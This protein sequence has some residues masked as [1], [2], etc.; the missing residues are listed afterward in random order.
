MIAMPEFVQLKKHVPSGTIII[1]RPE[2][3]NALSRDTVAALQQA[4]DDFHGER[5]VRAIILT[6]SG[7]T[8][9]SGT[10]LRELSEIAKQPNAMFEWQADVEHFQQLLETMWR[11]PKPII[12]AASGWCTGTGLALLL[13]C[14]HVI[15]SDKLQLWIPEA[16]RG[17]SSGLTAPLLAFRIGAGRANRLLYD[18]Q[19]IG[20]TPAHQL[21]IVHEIV[22]DDFVW[23]RAHQVANDIARGAAHSNLMAKQLMNETI[24]ETLLTQLAIGAAQTATARTTDAAIEGIT[25]FL[26][27]RPPKFI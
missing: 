3:R 18:A 24:G 26:E 22:A 23:A 7:N 25:A 13:A 5:S 14:D 19:P 4:F 8:F 6:G 27:K 2:C 15:G 21:G 16:L 12:A 1:N 17:L 11:F 9:S 20:S 10:D